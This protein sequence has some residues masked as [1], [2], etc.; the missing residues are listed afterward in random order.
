VDQRARAA[1]INGT[2]AAAVAVETIS[3]GHAQDGL[4]GAKDVGPVR[5]KDGRHGAKDTGHTV[6]N[7]NGYRHHANGSAKK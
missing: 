3:N 2:S 6:G 5:V 1:K 4:H 7:H